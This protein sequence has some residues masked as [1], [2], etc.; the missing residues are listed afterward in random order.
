MFDSSALPLLP[1]FWLLL[2]FFVLRA[3]AKSGGNSENQI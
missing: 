1:A 2:L 3:Y